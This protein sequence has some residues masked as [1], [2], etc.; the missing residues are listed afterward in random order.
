MR[1]LLHDLAFVD[2]HHMIGI[3]DG[4]EA[5]GDHELVR[6]CI[7]RSSDFWMRASVR[8]STDDVASSRIRIARVG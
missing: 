6:P 7:K 4:T 1:T 2:H 3:A 8:V 5:M